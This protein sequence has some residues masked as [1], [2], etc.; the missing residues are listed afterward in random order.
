MTESRRQLRKLS[1]GS[2]RLGA[3]RSRTAVTCV[4]D[5]EIDGRFPSLGRKTRGRI[6]AGIGTMSP[7]RSKDKWR[8]R[9]ACVEAKQSREVAGS[10]RCSER[11]MDENVPRACNRINYYRRSKLVIKWK[12]WRKYLGRQAIPF[13]SHSLFSPVAPFSPFRLFLFSLSPF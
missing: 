6:P 5:R 4:E 11:K 2:R 9:E 13:L 12:T 3:G 10:V 8:D 1:G 7:R